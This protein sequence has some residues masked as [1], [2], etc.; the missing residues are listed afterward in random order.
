MLAMYLCG[1]EHFLSD[2]IIDQA[3]WEG[4]CFH[5]MIGRQD[6]RMIID[7]FGASNRFAMF[8]TYDFI[9]HTEVPSS[10]TNIGMSL[11]GAGGRVRHG[12]I[13]PIPRDRYEELITMAPAGSWTFDR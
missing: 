9:T 1:L 7:G 11:P 10:Q 13:I 4:A 6:W 3:G 2:R 8:Q 12:T 5:K